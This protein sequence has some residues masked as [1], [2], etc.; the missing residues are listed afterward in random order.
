MLALRRK[1]R[2]AKN[3]RETRLELLNNCALLCSKV[4][5]NV[6]CSEAGD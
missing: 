3:M 2:R 5:A 1:W 4:E 6:E